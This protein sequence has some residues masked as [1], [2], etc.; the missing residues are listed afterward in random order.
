MP[1]AEIMS[2]T[3]I[4]E[5]KMAIIARFAGTCDWLRPTAA[6]VPRDTEIKVA[7]GAIIREFQND[8]V[9]SPLESYRTPKKSA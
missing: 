8:R 7:R 4:G 6:N 3:I 5:I 1:V 2:G 9:H